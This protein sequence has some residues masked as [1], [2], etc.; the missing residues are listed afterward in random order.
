MIRISVVSCLFVVLAGTALA[1]E[2]FDQNVTPDVIFGTGNVNGS[3]TTDRVGGLEIGLRGKLRYNASCLPENTF[4]SNGDG[5]YSFIAG[6]APDGPGGAANCAGT[7]TPVWSFEWA[8]NVD[9]LGALG[10]SI[11]DLVYEIGLDIDPSTGTSYCTWD[12]LSDPGAPAFWDHS[13]GNNSTAN[14]AGV[15]ATDNASYVALTQNNNVAQ[16]S[17]RYDFFDDGSLFDPCDYIFDPNVDATY[18]IY[19][20]ATDPGNGI[21]IAR[22]TIDIIVGNG[23]P[24]PVPATGTTGLAVLFVGLTLALV[25]GVALRRYR[26]A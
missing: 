12:P 10:G 7:A 6:V 23:G 11:D 2:Q 4:N 15:E 5:T 8:V 19:L 9:Y 22:S 21:E 20:S 1:V 16:Q 18:T 14:G 26:S 17:W 13:F 24:P 25:G 3:Y